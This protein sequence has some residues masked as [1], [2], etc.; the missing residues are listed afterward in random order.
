MAEPNASAA[1]T[2]PSQPL[3]LHYTVSTSH[4]DPPVFSGLRNEDVEE[5]L[6]SYDRTSVCNYWDEAHKLRYVPFYLDG[7]AKTWY[8]NHESDFSNWSAFTGHLRQVFGTSAGCSV[9]AKQKLATRIQG[10]DES[11]TSYIEDILALC[12]RAQNDMTE[13][14]RVRHL[15]KGINSVAFNALVIQNPTT[16]RDVITT[17]QR[18]DALHSM[19]LPHASCDARFT[20]EHELRALIRTIVREELHGLIPGNPTVASVHTP[21]PNLREIIKDELASMTSAAHAPSPVR[22]PVPSYAEVASRAPAPVPTVPADVGCDHVAAMTT[23]APRPRHYST[24]RPPRPICF[25]CGIRGHI[26]RFCRRRQQDE[27]RGYSAYERDFAPRPDEY[28]PA[29][30][31][32]TF[33]QSPSPPRSHAGPHPSRSSRRRSPS[34][35]RRTSSPLRPAPISLDSEN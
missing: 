27:R 26:S 32:S 16:V 7:V 10:D 28:D 5:W 4:R 24:W 6:D 33:R 8:Y 23:Q 14:D 19:R 13:A 12:R 15:L 1:A 25:Y 11:Y 17:C 3:R 18:L 21:P 9:V 34:P 20:K 31:P 2:A 29:P 22:F 35:F 30:Y